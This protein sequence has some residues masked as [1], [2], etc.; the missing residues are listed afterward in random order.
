MSVQKVTPGRT[1]FTVFGSKVFKGMAKKQ[2]VKMVP[3]S[4]FVMPAL[5][6]S[7]KL[8]PL[9]LSLLHTMSFL[10]FSD[11][12][13]VDPDHAIEAMESVGAYLQ[14]LSPEQVSGIQSQLTKIA[15]YARKK[16]LS[17]EFVEFIG[18]FLQNAG[19]ALEDD[20][21]DE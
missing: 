21:W 6:A 20:E 2:S 9:L 18:D 14:R 12:D 13:A 1:R 7:L 16:K 11:D 8:D 17:D 19:V 10:E 4:A 3:K 5:P 15:A